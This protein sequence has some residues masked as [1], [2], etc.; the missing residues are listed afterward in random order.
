MSS[1]R[2]RGGIFISYR[3]EET[4]AN[5]GRLYDRLS[6]S[7]GEDRVF[8]DVD[9]I[10]YGVDFTRAVVDAVSG[11]DVLLVLIGR[12]WLAIA[13][14]KGRRRLDNRDDWVRVEIETALQRDIRVVPVLVDGAALP[15]ASDLPS[16]LRPLVH[17]AALELSHTGFQSEVTRLIAAVGEVIEVGPGRTEEVPKNPSRRYATGQ[18]TWKLERVAWSLLTETFRLS[19]EGEEAHDI[20]WKDRWSHDALTVDGKLAIRDFAPNREYPLAALSSILGCDV[21]ITRNHRTFKNSSIILKV[22]NQIVSADF[23]AH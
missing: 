9:S 23:H 10:A 5:A 4:S 22:G 6:G 15:Q 21:T 16:S 19:S 13:D 3:R 20:A 14:S 11:C 1:L 18:R 17:R 2:G 7:F 12:N 8:M